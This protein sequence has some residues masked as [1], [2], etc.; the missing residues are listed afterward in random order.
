[1]VMFLHPLFAT[2]QPVEKDCNL[3]N[4][5]TVL[6]CSWLRTV[7]VD[8]IMMFWIK[9]GIR[10]PCFIMCG[11]SLRFRSFSSLTRKEVTKSEIT[12]FWIFLKFGHM[13]EED[14]LQ[15]DAFLK[16]SLLLPPYC[17]Y[18]PCYPSYAGYLQ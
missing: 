1:M 14:L 4:E 16:M 11:T 5:I 8:D 15:S 9:T 6:S 18:Y 13:K 10:D 17:H 3:I 12:D 7:V 2:I